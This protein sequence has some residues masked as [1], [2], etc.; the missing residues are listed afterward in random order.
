MSGILGR[1]RRIIGPEGEA[2]A[3]PPGETLDVPALR[4]DAELA[5]RL[6]EMHGDV[7]PPRASVLAMLLL[8]RVD[9]LLA[10]DAGSEARILVSGLVRRHLPTTITTWVGSNQIGAAV[11]GESVEQQLIT[12]MA[13]ADGA[14]AT[15]RHRRSA[16]AQVHGRFLEDR[17]AHRDLDL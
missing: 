14:V 5:R 9:L 10:D 4:H 17:Y 11:P 15:E 13:G 1:L 6:V 12:L 7:L 2:P 16:D 8:D 3:Q